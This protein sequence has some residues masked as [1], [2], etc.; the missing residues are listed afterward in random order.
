VSFEVRG[1][2]EFTLLIAKHDPG[3]GIVWLAFASLITGLVITF[4]LPRR[5]VW[6]R[7][8]RDGHLS[9]VGRFDRYVDFVG[10]FGRLV[11]DL[12][13]LRRAGPGPG[14]A[15]PLGVPLQG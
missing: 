10:E 11:D 1:F 15:A 4:W 14:P 8:D 3:Q 5:R 2:G 9:L 7:V 13:A 12:V 6:A